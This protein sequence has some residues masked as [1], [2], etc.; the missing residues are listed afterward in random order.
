MNEK[1]GRLSETLSILIP[2]YNEEGNLSL[3]HEK[4]VAALK[5]VGR[6]YEVIFIDDGSSDGSL[7][8]LLDLRDKNPNI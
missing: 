2:V 1:G 6:P 3:L 4:L 5:K 7:E 8:I